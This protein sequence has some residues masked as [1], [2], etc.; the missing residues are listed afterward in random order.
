MV[1]SMCEGDNCADVGCGFGHST[2]ILDRLFP[3][4]WTGVEFNQEAAKRAKRT[5]PKYQFEYCPSGRQLRQIGP[6]DTV[7]CSEVIEHVEDDRAFVDELVRAARIK[8]V[9]STPNIFVDDPGHLR[10]YTMATL[11]DLLS[12]YK[13]T[14]KSI[15]GFFYL[16]VI[17]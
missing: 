7:V 14:I 5:F 17:R 13:H 8:V 4:A 16:E 10:V 3:A 12:G 2:R 11:E 15:G 9:L 6:F 1:A